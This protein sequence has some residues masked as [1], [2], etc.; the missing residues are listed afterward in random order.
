MINAWTL[1]LFVCTVASIGTSCHPHLP[2]QAGILSVS[3]APAPR[4]PPCHRRW[5]W[6]SARLSCARAPRRP[7]CGPN[8]EDAPPPGRRR[9]RLGRRYHRR[10]QSDYTDGAR[11]RERGWGWSSL[12][13]KW[14]GRWLKTCQSWSIEENVPTLKENLRYQNIFIADQMHF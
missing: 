8:P 12:Y 4:W 1:F 13:F 9:R 14:I 11:Q 5:G 3:E 6:F 7:L 10:S 2:V